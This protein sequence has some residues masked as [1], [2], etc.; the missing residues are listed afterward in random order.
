MENKGIWVSA[1]GFPL[2]WLGCEVLGVTEYGGNFFYAVLQTFYLP[3][4]AAVIAVLL[5][6]FFCFNKRGR[7]RLLIVWVACVIVVAG[8]A[9]AMRLGERIR[10]NALEE[11]VIRSQPLVDAISTYT[12]MHGR[13]PAE[14]ADMVPSILEA[15]PDSKFAGNTPYIYAF[16]TENWPLDGNP[17]ILYLRTTRGSFGF[18]RFIYYPSETYPKL[19]PSGWY[20]P[21]GNWAYYHE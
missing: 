6:P 11:L 8:S 1:F 17:W 15:I 19:G 18:D 9:G 20:E 12:D 5:L 10:K 7:R 13:P 3:F 2:V 4:L 14:L 21:I 16:S